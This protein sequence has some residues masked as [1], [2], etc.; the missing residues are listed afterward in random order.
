MYYVRYVSRPEDLL[1]SLLLHVYVRMRGC[2][3]ARGLD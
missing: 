3:L 2:L 1:L